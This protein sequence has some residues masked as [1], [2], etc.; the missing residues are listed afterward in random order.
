[1]VMVAMVVMVEAV[2]LVMVIMTVRGSDSDIDS[3]AAVMRP[4]LWG[5]TTLRVLVSL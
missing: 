2:T 3:H 1:M 5:T 4:R